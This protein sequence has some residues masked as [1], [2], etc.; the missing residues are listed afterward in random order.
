[1]ASTDERVRC[2]WAGTDPLMVAYHDD[3]WGFETRDGRELFELLLLEGFQAGLSWSTILRRREGLRAAYDGFDPHVLAAYDEARVE[4]LLADPRI[5]RHRG[6]VNGAVQNAR[7]YLALAESEGSFSDWVWSFVGGQPRR[8]RRERMEDV[9]S[10][11][12]ESVALSRALRKA[13]FTFV[14]PTIV[15]AFMQS[16]G[17]VDDHICGCFRSV[18][19]A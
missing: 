1:V 13:G 18:A 3:E 9:P 4:A 10:Q 14:G 6:K 17:L 2:G 12:P 16:A 19:S 8:E 11:T 7:A 15:Y 5:I